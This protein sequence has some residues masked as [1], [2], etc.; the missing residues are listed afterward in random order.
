MDAQEIMD[1]WREITRRAH[2]P[3]GT[4]D[5]QGRDRE[6]GQLIAEANASGEWV[7]SAVYGAPDRYSVQFLARDGRLRLD[8]HYRD[9][10]DGRTSA[11]IACRDPRHTDA[12]PTWPVGWGPTVE[13][14]VGG[15]PE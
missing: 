2:R 1:R 15:R 6:I 9:R 5:T 14:E 4:I 13:I 12:D 3:G 7:A 11:E 10:P 8:A